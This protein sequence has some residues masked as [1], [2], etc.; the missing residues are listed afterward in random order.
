MDKTLSVEN[1]V[2]LFDLQPHP[3]GGYYKET[4]RAEGTLNTPRGNRN[5]ATAIYYLLTEGTQSR[6]HR[7]KQQD[8]IMH[9]YLGDP[10]TLVEILPDG[11]IENTILGQDVL[12]GQKLQHVIKAGHWFALYPNPGSR[13]GLIGCTV[14]PGFEFDD[15]EMDKKTELLQKFPHAKDIIEKLA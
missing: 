4:Y 6:L 11:K 9:F 1:L 14:S 13:F 12:S 7:L 5:H 3:E 10:L 15:F 2:S 8:E